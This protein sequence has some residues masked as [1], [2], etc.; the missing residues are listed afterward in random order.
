MKIS[1][2]GGI[3]TV[4]GSMHLVEVNSQKI[5]LDCG[6]FQGKRK[7]AFAKNRNL[8]LDA[9]SIN[10]LILGHAHIDHSGNIP[11][12][13]KNGYE[14]SIYATHATVDLCKYMLPDSGF[15]QEK[16]V[17]YVNKKRKKQGKVLFEPLYTRQD[18]VNS[19]QFFV[20]QSYHKPF[21]VTKNVNVTFYDAGHILGSA[22]TKLSITE[23]GRQI[24]MGYIVD[25]GRKNLPILKDPE[26]IPDLD[27]IIIESTYGGRLHDNIETAED[28]L[29]QIIQKTIERGGKV[30]IP[31][32]ALERTQEIVYV[33]NNLWNA[34]KL[35]VVP[36]YVDSPLA[37]N[38]TSVFKKH[39]EC[40]DAETIDVLSYDDDPFGFDK[41]KYVQQVED[42]KLINTKDEPCIIISAS[43]MC[44]TGRILHHL[45]N[46]IE[47]PRNTVIIV[48]F[49]AQNTLGRK[50]LDR[51][52]AV[53]IFGEEYKVKADIID[54]N[55]FSAHADSDDLVSY[56][57][58]A[59]RNLKGVFLVHGEESQSE[60]LA[61]KLISIGI[62]GVK[63]PGIKETIEI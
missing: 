2:L 38:V 49:M 31:S 24:N 3:R 14:K 61:E 21:Q 55:A 22:L 63:I 42:S 62:Q 56:V 13:V 18:A 11:N 47:N 48:G 36:V 43:G 59:N 58:Q 33:L 27:Y 44:E 54:M 46:N 32:F 20:G 12:L 17:E 41:L 40:F 7:D 5:V 23:N 34:R 26:I 25:L 19:L 4:T 28:K 1:F 9:D 30:I 15:I 53:K 37:V 57:K 52:P 39:K 50:L 51:W 8:P 35:P 45:K 60:M 6:L 16:D 29:R 10:A